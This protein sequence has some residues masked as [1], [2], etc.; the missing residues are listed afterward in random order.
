[1]V[2]GM[3]TDRTREIRPGWPVL[4]QEGKEL[5]KI[6]EVREDYLL[7]QAGLL[8]KHDLYI[9]I[10][11]IATVA[12]DRVT[13]RAHAGQIEVKNWR[14]P[15]NASYERVAPVAPEVPQT[16]TMQAAGFSAGR[17]SAPETQGAVHD[18]AT[19]DETALP[20][21]DIGPDSDDPGALD[22][23]ESKE[24]H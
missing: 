15:P 11:E 22:S 2:V 24:S 12:D 16:T 9:P 23:E 20:R 17:L 14:F 10:D 6:S 21:A 3:I 7:V 1:M 4:D 19:S 8:F 18:S 13:L 5:G